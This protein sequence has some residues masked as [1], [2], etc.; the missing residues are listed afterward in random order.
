MGVKII[1]IKKTKDLNY[2]SLCSVNLFNT[3]VSQF[4]LNSWNKWTFPRHSNLL[5]CTCMCQQWHFIMV[6]LLCWS[7]KITTLHQNIKKVVKNLSRY[8]IYF[9][10]NHYILT[11]LWI[12]ISYLKVLVLLLSQW[13]LSHHQ[14]PQARSG[15]VPTLRQ[16]NATHNYNYISTESMRTKI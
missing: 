7:K 3:Q 14:C 12:G 4:E 13:F 15:H 5:R 16:H 11:H 6:P 10:L 9:Q 1:T 2:F 8:I